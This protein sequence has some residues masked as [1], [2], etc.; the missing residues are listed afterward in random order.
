MNAIWTLDGDETSW[1]SWAD[2]I[3]L[4]PASHFIQELVVSAKTIHVGWALDVGCGTGRAFLPLTEAGYRVIGI[5]PIMNSIRLC[6]QRVSQVSIKAY[7]LLAS[8][9]HIPL[10]DQ[11]IGFVFAVNSLFHLSPAELTAAFLEIHRVLQ[12]QGC[13]LLHFLALDDWRHKLAK[14]I[15]PEQAPLPGYRFVITCFC[16]EEK[17]REWIYRA[18][19]T[20]IK[21][22]LKSIASEAGIQRNWLALC[23]K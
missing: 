8:A 7:P 15:P 11:T 12:P 14:E 9:T 4:A 1:G 22:E 13:A 6:Q 5:D 3:G 21:I 10:S 19:L 2:N 18:G 23:K 17:I 20:L 16:S